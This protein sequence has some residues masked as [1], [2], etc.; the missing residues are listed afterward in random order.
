MEDIATGMSLVTADKEVPV[1]S[2][3]S[4]AFRKKVLKIQQR[5]YQVSAQKQLLE[6]QDEIKAILERHQIEQE[7]EKQG[8][9]R[10]EMKGD[11][12]ITATNPTLSSRDRRQMDARER[13]MQDALYQ[14]ELHL[15]QAYEEDLAMMKVG[16]V[17]R[18]VQAINT[19]KLYARYQK[20]WN[21]WC[22]RRKYENNDVENKRF[23][24]YMTENTALVPDPVNGIEPIRVGPR[25]GSKKR[26]RS[27]KAA[28]KKPRSSNATA[29][30][31]D[32]SDIDASDS[33]DDFN[34]FQDYNADDKIDDDDE[35]YNSNGALPAYDT[36]DMYIKA[37]VDL[38][39]IQQMNPA[40]VYLKNEPSPRCTETRTLMTRHLLRLAELK[41]STDSDNIVIEDGH[42][43]SSLKQILKDK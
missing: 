40:K 10:G 24:L 39:L 2:T 19:Q 15:Q 16:A 6:K 20:H 32:D 8:R 28:S 43:L 30:I 11:A 14:Q 37:A 38:Q 1:D 26:K 34:P 36:L 33:D 21:K 3:A 13:A 27:K 41:A 25:G 17:R 22:R 35:P 9:G 4:Q 12:S 42:G 31:M 7:A 29:D 23:V 18:D 5:E